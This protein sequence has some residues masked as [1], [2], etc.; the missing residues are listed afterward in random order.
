MHIFLTTNL[1]TYFT[2]W[3][4][5]FYKKSQERIS[6]RESARLPPLY[7]NCYGVDTAAEAVLYWRCGGS[8][9]VYK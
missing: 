5:L 6:R 4:V 7:G 3:V 1:T 8:H 9:M 2:G